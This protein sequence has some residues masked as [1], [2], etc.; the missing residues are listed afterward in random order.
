MF[1]H[2]QVQTGYSLLSS[3]ISVDKLVTR[4]SELGYQ[5]CAITDRN[6]MYGVVPFY[7]ACKQA[8]IKPIIGLLAD[9]E[10]VFQAGQSFPL[11]LLAKNNEG[12]QHLLK[13]SSAIQTAKQPFIPLHWLKGYSA[14]LFAFTPGADGEVEKLL[15]EDPEKAEKAALQLKELFA[16][17]HFFLS[18]GRREQE[19][20]TGIVERIK[21]LGQTLSIPVIASSR[22][23]HLHREEAFALRCLKAIR[24]G[25]KLSD[26]Q[27]ESDSGSY[28]ASPE[29]AAAWFLDEPEVLQETARLAEECQVDLAFGRHLLP[30]YPLSGGQT[31]SAYLKDICRKAMKQAGTEGEPAYEQRLSYEL[32]IIEEMGFSDYFLIVWDF[33]S[34]AKEQRILTGPGRGSAAGSLV[35]YLLG[36]TSVDP[37]KY[38]LL[39]ERFLNPARISMPDIDL[40]FPDHRRDEVIRYIGRKFGKLHAAQIITF[41]TLSAKAVMRDIA[42]VFHFSTKD[43]EELSRVLSARG[44]PTLQQQYRE[45]ARFRDWVHRSEKHQKIYETA[46]LLEGLPRHTST[47]AAGMVITDEPLTELTAVQAGHDD[48]YLTQFPM[49]AL[50]ELGLLKIDLLGL[51]NLTILERILDSIYYAEG[52][53]L[54]LQN[55]PL[56]D[57]ATFQLLGEGNTTGIFQMES[58]GMRRVLKS[59][60][61]NRFEDI[62]AVNA[63][64][65]PGPMES[66]PLYIER[67]HGKKPVAYPHPDLQKILEPTYGVLI[68]Q[69]QIMRIASEFAGFSLGE[70]DLLRRA[71][72][73]KNREV[74]QQERKHFISGAAANGYS[75]EEADRVYRLIVQFANYG[76]NRSHAVAYSFITY[77]LAYLK[78]HYPAI[79]MASLMSSALGNEEKLKQCTIEAKSMGLTLLLPSINSSQYPFTAEGNE[80]RFSLAAVKGVGAA[81]VKEITAARKNGPFTDLFNFC[82]RVP[83]HIVNRNTIE[84]LIQAGAMDEFGEDR[85]VLL[86]TLEAAIEHADLMN[87]G[88]ESS[89][90][91]DFFPKPKYSK[92]APMSEEERL[93]HEKKAFGFYVSAHPAETY[94]SLF[95][96]AGKVLIAKLS[97][98]QRGIS[99]GIFIDEVKVIRTKTGENMAFIQGSD[100]SGEIEGVVFPAVY[101][102][103][104]DDLQE[105]AVLFV[106][107]DVEEKNR[108]KKL[109]VKDIYTAAELKERQSEREKTLYVKIPGSQDESLVLEDIHQL[110]SRFKGETAVVLHY[111]RTRRTVRLNSKKYVKPVK[112]LLDELKRIVGSENVVLKNEI[113]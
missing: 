75:E 46:L 39:F 29:E 67:K 77:G 62:V 90:D 14:G 86:A 40:D 88:G 26:G 44:G 55:I 37:I 111:E 43:L 19:S 66:I 48:L 13:I 42:R 38:G 70:A 81:A 4:A 106:K 99:A 113:K 36:I 61:P 112:P 51:R 93:M 92:A 79:F 50:E 49:D 23:T 56:Q 82:L 11:V 68:Y 101:R 57:E 9:V 80:I 21:R 24:D 15:M 16:S 84:S 28:F 18:I 6:V 20:E 109:I 60:K 71:V 78:A 35:A 108:Q 100:E 33:M 5:A 83:L 85:A 72:S 89:M 3:T 25:E 102:V 58:E 31:A 10:S 7:K 95:K 107:G 17:E 47:H 30:K 96:Q 73:K 1:T 22:V 12:Y 105:G 54:S 34:F 87:P 53:K 74:L 98:G 64:Y 27:T 41:G 63:L 2:L 76:F 65:R 94:D 103:H 52:K 69:E 97:S 8:G 110:I 45:S 32:K 104:M 91:I 59:L